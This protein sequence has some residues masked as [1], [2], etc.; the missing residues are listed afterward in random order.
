[1][2]EWILK[3]NPV[4]L[5]FTLLMIYVG[6][7]MYQRDKMLDT[8]CSVIDSDVVEQVAHDKEFE[9]AIAICHRYD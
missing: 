1:M 2:R 9:E 5:A 6:Y 7:W 8:V 4:V 3:Y